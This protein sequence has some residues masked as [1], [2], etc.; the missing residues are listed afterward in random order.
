MTGDEDDPCLAPG[1]FLKQHIGSAGLLVL[2]KTGHTINL[3][4]PEPFNRAVLD[5]LTLAESGRWPKREPQ[6]AAP[7]ALLPEDRR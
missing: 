4:E 7:S 2:P 3:E 1:L 5:F 6:P